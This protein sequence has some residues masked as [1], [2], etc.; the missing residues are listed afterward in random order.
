MCFVTFNFFRY[1]PVI[2]KPRK[3][4]A[5]NKAIENIKFTLFDEIT[6][7]CVTMAQI[8]NKIYFRASEN[9]PKNILQILPLKILTMVI[10]RSQQN[11]SKNEIS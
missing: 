10:F 2:G 4:L 8:G 1:T 6:D 3:S 11:T 5:F 9:S 7:M